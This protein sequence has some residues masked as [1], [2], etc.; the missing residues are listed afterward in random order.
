MSQDV[1]VRLIAATLAAGVIA[2]HDRGGIPAV[3][4]VDIYLEIL[5]ASTRKPQ[6]A[7]QSLRPDSRPSARPAK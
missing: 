1:D 2:K 6:T 3:D 4:A 5:A 7:A